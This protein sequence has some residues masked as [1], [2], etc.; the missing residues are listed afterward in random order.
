MIRHK[1]NTSV[2]I[3]IPGSPTGNIWSYKMTKILT[4]N[5]IQNLCTCSK[6]KCNNSLI[7]NRTKNILK[8]E[9]EGQG[10]ATHFP[11]GI[12]YVTCKFYPH[13][14]K[15]RWI[16]IW[17]LYSLNCGSKFS[18]FCMTKYSMAI[19]FGHTKLISSSL[20]FCP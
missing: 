12:R 5:L 15:I 14:T 16:R 3:G 17:T 4:H 7:C 2:D 13:N 1:P 19:L 9:K 8:N 18:S 6:M 10:N 11:R 20:G